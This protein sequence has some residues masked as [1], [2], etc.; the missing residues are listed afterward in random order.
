[1]DNT[2]TYSFGQMEIALSLDWVLGIFK[3]PLGN[4]GLSERHVHGKMRIRSVF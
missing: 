1:M 3:K 2:H 4:K